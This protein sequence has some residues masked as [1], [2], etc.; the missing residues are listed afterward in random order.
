M[1]GYAC[2]ESRENDRYAPWWDTVVEAA[3]TWHGEE[4]GT[5]RDWRE[6]LVKHVTDGRMACGCPCSLSAKRRTL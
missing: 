4:C 6:Y 2:S 3:Q 5:C 1:I